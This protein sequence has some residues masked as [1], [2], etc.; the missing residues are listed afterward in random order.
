MG[1]QLPP[2]APNFCFLIQG[3]TS[4]FLLVCPGRARRPMAPSLPEEARKLANSEGV[5]PINFI[6][7]AVAEK[8]SAW[9]TEAYFDERARRADAPKALRVLERAGVGNPP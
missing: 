7:I 3:D 9:R 6:N 5:A 2:P 8:V 4:R 1:V